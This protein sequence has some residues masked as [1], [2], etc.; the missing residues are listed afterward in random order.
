MINLLPPEL[1]ADYRYARR[2]T[3]L[4]N[5]L[6]IFAV[7]FAGLAAITLAGIFY[8]QQAS[9][10]YAEQAARQQQSLEEQKQ[11]EV[12]AQVQDISSSLKLAVQVLSQEVLFSQLL[13]QLATAIP[14]N[15]SLTG[16]TI[17]DLQGGINISA[18]TASYESATQLQ[19]NLS[20]PANKIFSKADIL[21]INC[22]SPS[23]DAGQATR[24]P[25]QVSI[26]AQFA[27]DNPF[28]FINNKA[29]SR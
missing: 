3:R 11:S 15:T 13:R 25:C 12:K 28:L 24:Y 21:N 20:D 9:K 10:T 7:G 2:N 26:R 18:M 29:G 5:L 8:L 4:V 14:N 6:A 19:V 16:M 17:A 27:A 23:A 22:S 1:K